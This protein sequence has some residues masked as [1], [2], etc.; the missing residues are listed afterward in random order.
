MENNSYIIKIK[1][2]KQNIL[3]L[4]PT[5]DS[6]LNQETEFTYK[7]VLVVSEK[8][9]KNPAEFPFDIYLLYRRN[10]IE[11]MFCFDIDDEEEF[12]EKYLDE[13]IIEI[14]DVTKIYPSN[15]IQMYDYFKNFVL[16]KEQKEKESECQ[17]IQKE[18]E[19][20]KEIV[21][22]EQEKQEPEQ[23]KTI[24]KEYNDDVPNIV[25]NV[26]IQ[27]EVENIKETPQVEKPEPQ[28]E[29]NK[30]IVTIPKT[31]EN[32]SF[33]E[34]K[35]TIIFSNITSGRPAV[36][37]ALQGTLAELLFQIATARYFALQHNISNVYFYHSDIW[38][39]ERDNEI[40]VW[41]NINRILKEPINIISKKEEFNNGLESITNLEID[42]ITYSEI[43]YEQDKNIFIE[44]WRVNP[45]YF[46]KDFFRNM[47]NI[48]N[49][50]DEARRIYGDLSGL[51]AIYISANEESFFEDDIAAIRKEF[52]DDEFIVFSDD[53]NWCKTNLSELNLRFS[54]DAFKS[55]TV[56]IFVNF[57]A[58]T[59]CYGIITDD[60]LEA[61]LAAWISDRPNHITVYKENAFVDSL[62]PDDKTWFT[63][64]KFL[65][66]NN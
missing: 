6:L 35:K 21:I 40:F 53:I 5:I 19:N 39:K 33:E 37:S 55:D 3:T 66:L 52:P 50:A 42:A 38:G 32:L 57:A 9:F 51:A 1:V 29:E 49:I 30:I 60:S 8:D 11:I 4:K 17:I 44:G 27:E 26:A 20:T 16:I 31:N 45:K 2:N 56:D 28:K 10:K 59:Q 12:I 64:K 15:Y 36:V 23:Q 62:I 61:W 22:K 41:Q 65:N 18:V 25:C 34:N 54:E 47:L 24:Q 58:M 13:N 63:F 7:I 46:T 48:D 14:I 43:K